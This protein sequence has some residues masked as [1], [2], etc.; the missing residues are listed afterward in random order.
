MNSFQFMFYQFRSKK[1]KSSFEKL[2][3]DMIKKVVLYEKQY[4]LTRKLYRFEWDKEM[5]DYNNRKE[6]ALESSNK[7]YNEAYNGMKDDDEQLRRSYAAHVSGI[8]ELEYELHEEKENIKDRYL[9]FFD[10][11][12]KSLIVSL[13]SLIESK[14]KDLCEISANEFDKKIKYSH[15]DT[16]DYIQSSINYFNLVIEMPTISIEAHI[17]K[18]KDIQFIRNR[19]VHTEGRF[20][21]DNEKKVEEIIKKGKG[22]LELLKSDSTMTLKIRKPEFITNFFELIRELFEELIWLIDCQQNYKILRKGLE[23]WF[24]ILDKKI[25][26]RNIKVNDLTKSKKSIEFDVS[27]RKRNIP[28]FKC[29][30]SLVRAKE[31]SLNIIDQTDDIAIKKFTELVDEMNELVFGYVFGVFNLSYSG[32]KISLMIY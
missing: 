22:E 25:F 7:I 26:I 11:H 3:D 5:V 15:L 30:L 32:L 8:D 17:S 31:N 6:I 20:T 9:D 21:D 27:S 29:K 23:Y 14:L 10:L 18:L 1:E 19:I 16:R 24:G 12:C 13:Y 4:E 28:R 2:F